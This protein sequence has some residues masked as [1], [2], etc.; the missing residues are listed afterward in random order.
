MRLFRNRTKRSEWF[1]GL[2][3]AEDLYQRGYEVDRNNHSGILGFTKDSAI[4]C[5]LDAQDA[6]RNGVNDY[7]WYYE[8]KLKNL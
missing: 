3:L 7:I 8:N 2:L 1:E 4:S 6:D 5:V